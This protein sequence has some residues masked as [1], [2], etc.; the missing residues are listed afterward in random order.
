MRN[1]TFAQA[2]LE[3]LQATP[4]PVATPK[5]GGPRTVLTREKFQR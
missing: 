5:T 3:V 4:E 1:E 2:D